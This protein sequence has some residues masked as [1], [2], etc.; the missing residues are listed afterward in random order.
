VAKCD[1]CMWYNPKPSSLDKLNKKRLFDFHNL[2]LD[3]FYMWQYV[4]CG[5]VVENP[6]DNDNWN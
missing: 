4:I 1:W 6:S 2:N 3:V 5:F